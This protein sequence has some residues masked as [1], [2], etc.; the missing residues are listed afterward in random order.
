VDGQGAISGS[1]G[2]CPVISVAAPLQPL[3]LRQLS[4]SEWWLNLEEWR[5]GLIIDEELHVISIPAGYRYNRASIP[6]ALE[7][8]VSKDDCGCP[9]PL[10]HDALCEYNGELLG[11]WSAHDWEPSCV[12]YHR[13]SPHE[14]A[15]IFR[16]VMLEDGVDPDK[17]GIAYGAVKLFG[18]HW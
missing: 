10:A 5:L 13:F 6:D 2:V 14:A 9:G 7:F 16:A 1:Q 11:S 4:G 8:I 17:A 15:D 18:R 3:C 12:P